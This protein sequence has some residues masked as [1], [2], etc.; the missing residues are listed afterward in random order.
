MSQLRG[1][2]AEVVP[3][4][5]IIILHCFRGTNI[6]FLA[7]MNFVGE[8]LGQVK[9]LRNEFETYTLKVIFF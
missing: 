7:L 1:A 5:L 3:G 6:I 4:I 8:S 9:R 2:E